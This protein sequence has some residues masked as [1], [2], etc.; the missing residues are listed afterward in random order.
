MKKFP[1]VRFLGVNLAAIEVSEAVHLACRGGLFLAPSGPGL[2]DLEFD[3]EYRNALLGA[4]VNLPDSGLAIL[5]ARFLRMGRLPRTSGLGFLEALLERPELQKAGA[6]FWVMPS[7]ESMERNLVW[8]RK[9]GLQVCADDCYIAPLYPKRG[10]VADVDLLD[11]LCKR[12]VRFVFVCTG[13]GTQEKLGLW[14]KEN[15]PDRPAICCIGAAIGF[16]SGDQVRIPNWSDRMCLGWLFRCFSEPKK[17]V[18]RYA[19]ATRL[20]WLA[21]RHHSEPPPIAQIF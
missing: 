18:P 16:L 15:L 7:R 4:D 10:P 9:K 5:L 1:S 11:R 12:C 8:L 6:T 14:L 17:F 20:I 13:S 3:K 19:A 21:L 2:C